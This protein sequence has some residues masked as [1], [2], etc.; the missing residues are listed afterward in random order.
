MESKN[1]VKINLGENPFDLACSLNQQ[2]I[3]QQSKQLKQETLQ[4]SNKQ[5]EFY[6]I[7]IKAIG[8]IKEEVLCFLQLLGQ[9]EIKKLSNHSSRN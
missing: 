4:Q 1:N 8:P 2:Q 9:V 5:E 6:E 7:K 3:L